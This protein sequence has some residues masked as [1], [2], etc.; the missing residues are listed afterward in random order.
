MNKSN[1]K[2]DKDLQVSIGEVPFPELVENLLE[3]LPREGKEK[4]GGK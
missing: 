4:R 2:K 3:V 1:N